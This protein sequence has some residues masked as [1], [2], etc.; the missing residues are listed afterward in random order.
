[1]SKFG[2][3]HVVSVIVHFEQNKILIN[4]NKFI[5]RKRNK[6]ESSAA[7]EEALLLKAISHIPSK[8]LN[9]T[10]YKIKDQFLTML[11][12]IKLAITLKTE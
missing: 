12:R 7:V 3:S 8:I 9:S 5:C 4:T 1:M 6:I 10:L 2:S 11:F